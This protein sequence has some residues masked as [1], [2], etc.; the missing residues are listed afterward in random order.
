[1]RIVAPLFWFDLSP[2]DWKVYLAHR[3]FMPEMRNHDGLTFP[4]AREI[5][6]NAALTKREQD[7]IVYHEASHFGI[8]RTPWL[9]AAA[10]E[11]VV[12]RMT[13]KVWPLCRKMGLRWPDRPEGYVS[14]HRA[15]VRLER[16][17]TEAA[18]AKADA[19]EE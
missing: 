17:A 13:A 18:D 10:E 4:E 1:M 8:W 6:I 9:S 2:V 7:S 14:L 15:A 19:A 16:I 5:Y 12:R 3:G 11:R